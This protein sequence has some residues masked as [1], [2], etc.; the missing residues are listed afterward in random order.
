LDTTGL[1]GVSDVQR[2]AL[3]AL[4]AVERTTQPTAASLSMLIS[5]KTAT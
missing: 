5:R 2:A 1:T 4:G 3:M